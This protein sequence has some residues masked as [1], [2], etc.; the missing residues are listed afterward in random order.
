[1]HPAPI[2]YSNSATRDPDPSN[3]QGSLILTQAL[4]LALTLALSTTEHHRVRSPDRTLKILLTLIPE[5]TEP[6][7]QPLC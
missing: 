4:T 1:M 6:Y 3:Y 2:N 7:T 5:I